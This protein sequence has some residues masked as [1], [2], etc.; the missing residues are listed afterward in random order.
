LEG[1]AGRG[2]GGA[3]GGNGGVCCGGRAAVEQT[4]LGCAVVGGEGVVDG[5]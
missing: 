4:A 5:G 1:G 2:L 3:F